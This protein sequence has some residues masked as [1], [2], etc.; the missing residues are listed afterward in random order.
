MEGPSGDFGL[1]V[2]KFQA[3][4]EQNLGWMK[5]F[6]DQVSTL[7]QL[8]R[9][10][11]RDL[12]RERIAGRHAQE[13]SEKVDQKFRALEE[14]TV[15]S[16]FV[17]VLIDADADAYLFEDKYYRD[18]PADGG[19]RAA[20]DLRAAVRQHL[21]SIGGG[22]SGLPIMVKAFAS[23][24][25]LAYLLSKAGI[26]SQGQSQEVVSRFTR[27]F[28][29]ADDMF[30]FVLVGK[31]KDR[32]DHKLMAAFRQFAESPSCRRILLA[33]C[34]DN[35]YVRM[36]EKFVHNSA[37]AEKVTL[38]KSFQTGSE[39]AALPFA[40]TTMESI[41]RNRR[42]SVGG[43]QVSTP[44]FTSQNTSAGTNGG[45]VSVMPVLSRTDSSL[46][47]YEPVTPSTPVMT[48]AQPIARS[49]PQATYATRAAVSASP[50]PSLSRP[51]P[52]FGTL[53]SNVILVNA[54]DHRIDFA[55][56]PKSA[57]AVEKL[58]QK[59]HVGG[60]RY[61]NMYHLYGSCGGC[62]YLHDP[63]SAAEKIVLRHRLRGEKCH[64]RGRCRDSMCFYGH[65]CSC[66]MSKK[67]HFP[68]NMHNI[69]VS[70]WR[71]VAVVVN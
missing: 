6:F 29:Q 39:Y 37:V 58:H 8:Y 21:Q 60:K 2:E 26:A 24:E 55:L 50:P 27:G 14:S 69:D 38:L 54:D 70:T 44:I 15:R 3:Q 31:G 13:Q 56:P 9:D 61:C 62:N 43:G 4:T 32:A 19:E 7:S 42:L 49:S 53:G 12:E 67:C 40:S 34:H 18:D 47:S 71:E 65:H 46:S 22:L 17:L 41:F 10:A 33:G 64:D 35:G 28:S 25:G 59:T 52:L 45:A 48:A 66:P 36:L 16:A 11:C 63:I 51:V 1:F 57:S 5:A 20:I 30:D 68:G 23:G